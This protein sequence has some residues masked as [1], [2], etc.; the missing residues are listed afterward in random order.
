MYNYCMTWH[1][2]RIY[3]NNVKLP[4]FF[5][6]FRRYSIR[7]NKNYRIHHT[8]LTTT[9]PSVILPNKSVT[10]II[11]LVEKNFFYEPL[12]DDFFLFVILFAFNASYQVIYVL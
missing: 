3:I 1:N 4:S 7:Q 6:F 10:T 8:T 9:K 12:H 5:S 11:F 2:H